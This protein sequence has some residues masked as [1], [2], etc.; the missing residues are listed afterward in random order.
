MLA[1]FMET[2]SL[3]HACQHLEAMDPVVKTYLDKLSTTM[4]AN[5]KRLL[6]SPPRSMIYSLGAPDLEK[7]VAGLGG[8]RASASAVVV[9]VPS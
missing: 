3:R 7:C 2:R 4:E 1:Q 6:W 5:T 8:H 9:V